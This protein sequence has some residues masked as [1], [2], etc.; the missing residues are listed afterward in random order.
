[1][2]RSRRLIVFFRSSWIELELFRGDKKKTPTKGV[3]NKTTKIHKEF[4]LIKFFSL[5]RK[6]IWRDFAFAFAGR[7]LTRVALFAIF[8][9]SSYTLLKWQTFGYDPIHKQINIRR[10]FFS[11]D[12]PT[13][14]HK[15]NRL[16]YWKFHRS[17]RPSH[18]LFI[19]KWIVWNVLWR[20]YLC[21]LAHGAGNNRII[22]IANKQVA[23]SDFN[24][25]SE[26]YYHFVIVSY[27]AVR[28]D[29]I[30]YVICWLFIIKLVAICVY[31]VTSLPPSHSS[32]RS[33]WPDY[34]IHLCL[35]ICCIV[36]DHF[37]LHCFQF[38][39]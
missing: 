3:E 5:L 17:N 6:S 19:I 22:I 38:C 31:N 1:M 34:H 13:I 7:D 15:L 14:F 32:S 18:N 2:S 20:E 11:T 30:S 28:I 33:H 12:H 36:N 29:W 35:A 39:S 9:I 23:D 27:V 10:L 25:N 37:V 26:I 8:V 21:K 4:T 16:Y 24:N